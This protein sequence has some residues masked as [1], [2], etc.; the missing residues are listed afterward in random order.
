MNRKTG[1]IP[2]STT[3]ADTCPDACPFKATGVCYA[4]HGKVRM[5]W[6]KVSA[7]LRGM[8]FD[9]FCDA[10]R[11]LPKGI[12]WRHN[13]AGDLPG[14]A[15][16]LDCD[17]LAQLVDANRGRRGFTYTHKPLTTDAEREAVKNANAHG[18]TVNL[19]ANDLDH[20]DMLAGLDIGAV[21]TVLP[22][23]VYGNVP[24]F[25]P[26]G[27]RVVVCPA[28][29]R[30]EVTCESCGLCQRADRKVIVGFPAHGP[31]KGKY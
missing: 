15:D 30:D 11:E 6:D 21:V 16:T 10:V 3:S 20:A 19:S 5:H 31:G 9:A 27:R 23:D 25:T 24:I 12:L 22:G 29:Y 17:M 1:R 2:V 18:F 26:N 8:T 28:T 4:K 13:Q 7:G 14:S